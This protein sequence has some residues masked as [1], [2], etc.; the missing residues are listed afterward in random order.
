MAI[1]VEEAIQE[2]Q[3]DGRFS[4]LPGR[5]QRL[6]I[7]PSPDAVVNNLLKDAHVR[8][9]W[10]EVGCLIDALQEK[11]TRYCEQFRRQY[12]SEW[13]KLTAQGPK[14]QCL[15]G[16]RRW[17]HILWHGSGNRLQSQKHGDPINNLNRRCKSGITRYAALLHETNVQIRRFNYLVPQR[18]LQRHVLPVRERLEEFASNFPQAAQQQDLGVVPMPTEV[19]THLLQGESAKGHLPSTGPC[20]VRCQQLR[21]ALKR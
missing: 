11:T 3:R 17:W 2:A 20:P 9:E 12:E 19:P 18:D 5:G 6:N 10:I 4:N 21:G 16:W 7:D 1:D 13:Q 15:T 14:A 8:P